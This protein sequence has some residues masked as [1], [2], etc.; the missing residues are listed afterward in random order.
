MAKLGFEMMGIDISVD[1]IEKAEQR[2]D[3][4]LKMQFQQADI[5]QLPFADESVA[6]ILS[7]NVLEWVESPPKALQE[8]KRILKPDGLLCLGILGPT[9]LVHLVP[10]ISQRMMLVVTVSLRKSIC[11]SLLSIDFLE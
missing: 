10:L 5:I 1:M 8:V 4:G 2:M 7:I 11:F 6:G 9:S 3:H